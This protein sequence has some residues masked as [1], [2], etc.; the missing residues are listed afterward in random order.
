METTKKNL[1]LVASALAL[2]I[3]L[4]TN[5]RGQAAQA[6][7]VVTLQVLELNKIDLSS[8]NSLILTIA[9]VEPNQGEP[10][11]M[12]NSSTKLV[13]TSN[14][15]NR[16]IT[17]ASNN[18]N[19][20]YAL[21]VAAENVSAGAGSPVSEVSFFDN[22]TRDLIVGVSKAAGSCTLRFTGSAA[23]EQGAGVENHLITYTIVC[24]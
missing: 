7:Q 18:P 22:A 4:S 16:K 14:G 6:T 21:R 10:I 11:P 1:T 13:W 15:E 3:V 8:G 5:L 2:V 19:S 23:V 17:V 20:R 24:S 12:S 9:S